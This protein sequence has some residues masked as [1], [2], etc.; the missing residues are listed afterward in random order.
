MQVYTL[1]SWATSAIN[2]ENK[3][4]RTVSNSSERRRELE[5]LYHNNKNQNLFTLI[6]NSL[7]QKVSYQ[8]KKDQKKIKKKNPEYQITQS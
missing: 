6:L 3:T 7:N 5:G 2:R 4:S 8:E 1:A